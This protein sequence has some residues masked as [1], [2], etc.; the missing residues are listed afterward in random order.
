MEKI[1][2]GF[3]CELNGV[4]IKKKGFSYRL[5]KGTESKQIRMYI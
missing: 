2:L 4:I 1:S 3:L 5:G